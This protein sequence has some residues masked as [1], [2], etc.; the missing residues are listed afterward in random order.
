MARI[1]FWNTLSDRTCQVRIIEFT[2][3]F[4]W[5]WGNE[6]VFITI[7]IISLKFTE[8]EWF[9]ISWIWTKKLKILKKFKIWDAKIFIFN[10]LQN[11]KTPY[12]C[13]FLSYDNDQIMKKC[14]FL[15]E[16]LIFIILLVRAMSD[17]PQM[18]FLATFQSTWDCARQLLARAI[19]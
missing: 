17:V 2:P 11:F 13:E 4:E 7:M 8:I 16:N 3:T 5:N 12:L 15:S 1:K 14:L 18:S 9:E 6:Y 10:F 19:G